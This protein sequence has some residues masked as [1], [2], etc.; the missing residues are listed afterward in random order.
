MAV[1][2]ALILSPGGI[3]QHLDFCCLN[4]VAEMVL[5]LSLPSQMTQSLHF[6]V[7]VS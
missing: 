6:S 5:A 2:N 7:S 4:L 3:W 1:L